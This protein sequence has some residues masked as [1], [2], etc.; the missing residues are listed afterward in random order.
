[1]APLLLFEI[2]YSLWRLCPP[3]PLFQ[4]S[5]IAIT[6]MHLSQL[7]ASVLIVIVVLETTKFQESPINIAVLWALLHVS[8]LAHLDPL[9]DSCYG[10]PHSRI[11]IQILLHQ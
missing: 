6:S 3:D 5:T 1:M 9:I 4:R 7:S 8:I 10:W 11:I 2:L